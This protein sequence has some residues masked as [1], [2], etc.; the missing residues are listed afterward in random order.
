[1][2][3][4]GV[5]AAPPT[6]ENKNVPRLMR[7]TSNLVV[8]SPICGLQVQKIPFSLQPRQYAGFFS[9]ADLRGFLV[10]LDATIL[11]AMIYYLF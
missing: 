5:H 4:D 7:F 9:V 10:A 2:L 6:N 3:V 8:M 11:L 1:V